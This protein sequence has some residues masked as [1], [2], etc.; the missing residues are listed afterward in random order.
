MPILDIKIC[1]SDNEEKPEKFESKI[2]IFGRQAKPV[3]LYQSPR[4]KKPDIKMTSIERLAEPRYKMNL[5]ENPTGKLSRN[6]KFNVYF[7][8]SSVRNLHET[9]IFTSISKQKIKLPKISIQ[10]NSK[11]TSELKQ[12]VKNNP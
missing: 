10:R 2:S 11:S 12:T 1:E 9:S 5:P 6:N 7:T 4:W 8:S 3:G